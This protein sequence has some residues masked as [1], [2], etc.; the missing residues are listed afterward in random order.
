MKSLENISEIEAGLALLKFSTTTCS[1][2]K[3]Y[4][5]TIAMFE[6]AWGLMKVFD[7][8]AEKFPE[9]ATQFEIKTV[10]TLVFVYNNKQ[11]GAILPNVATPQAINDWLVAGAQTIAEDIAREMHVNLMVKLSSIMEGMPLAP[12]VTALRDL[13]SHTL[14]YLSE[15]DANSM[16]AVVGEASM[17]HRADFTAQRAAQAE[18]QAMAMAMASAPVASPVVEET[19]PVVEETVPVVEDSSIEAQCPECNGGC[20]ES[21]CPCE[22]GEPD[23]ATE[24]EQPATQEQES[25]TQEQEPG[26]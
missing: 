1:K 4:G 8:D 22:C 14:G 3:D 5:P 15:E 12:V 18:A 24:P 11:V 25:A 6:N 9:L 20:A 2:C 10:P 13:F 7:V 19:A 17:K 21:E 26:V 16:M 23:T